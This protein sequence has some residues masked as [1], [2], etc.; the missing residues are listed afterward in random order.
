[1]R[2]FDE[3]SVSSELIPPHPYIRLTIDAWLKSYH[4][5]VPLHIIKSRRLVISWLIA[6]LEVW[7]AGIRGGSYVVTADT[8][9]SK[10]GACG[11]IW[12]RKY[13]YDQLRA[14][15]PHWGLGEAHGV[16]GGGP[17]QHMTVTLPN[18]AT[19]EAVNSSGGTFQ[20]AGATSV[21]LE[22]L[23]QYREVEHIVAQAR[24]IVQGKSDAKSGM[25]VSISN[26]PSGNEEY[27]KLI[28]PHGSEYVLTKGIA[29]LREAD[30]GARVL[31]I[32]Y[33]ADPGKDE[34]WATRAK[35]GIPERQWEREMEGCIATYNGEPV[36]PEFSHR[37]HVHSCPMPTLTRRGT[38]IMGWDIGNGLSPAAVL[39]HVRQDGQIHCIAEF[40]R[41][42]PQALSVFCEDVSAKLN[43]LLMGWRSM[44]IRHTCDPA[45]AARGNNLVTAVDTLKAYGFVAKTST[46]NIQVRLSAVS[47]ALTDVLSE[48]EDE[49]VPR[50][51]IDESCREIIQ[52]LAGAY[53]FEERK[54]A[55]GVTTYGAKP[56]K[57]RFSHKQ[58][59]LQYAMIEANKFA[60]SS[61]EVTI[62][63]SYV[64]RS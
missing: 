58:D 28:E 41:R 42:E 34:A 64:V 48:S 32:H 63:D 38:L 27:L 4:D 54:N 20:G 39:L 33:M 45:G 22:E 31:E 8:Y 3:N 7:I 62:K 37:M 11:F 19:F 50:F 5:G 56:E 10:N 29:R 52:G 57:N 36:F 13:I 12:R 51:I 14:H 59:A 1:V 16:G 49:I 55:K 46:N 6:A 47:G 30:S 21:L 18:G 2:T 9:E 24:I 23:S 25:L 15:H 26:A 60:S 44:G 40:G 17:S 61:G 53:I 35:V 43:R